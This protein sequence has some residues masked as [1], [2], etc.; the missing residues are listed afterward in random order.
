MFEKKAE[1]Y[2][3]AVS[4][5][6]TCQPAWHLRK[7]KLRTASYPFDWIGTP[8]DS[9]CTLLAT[10]F[11]DFF[12]RPY[13]HIRGDNEIGKLD[14]VNTKY[15][16]LFAHDFTAAN[17]FDEEYPVLKDKFERRIERFCDVLKSGERVLLI[18]IRIDREDARKITDTLNRKFPNLRYTL[19]A[20]DSTEEIREDWHIPNVVNRY[21]DVAPDHMAVDPGHDKPWKKA[22]KSFQYN[23][24][25]KECRADFF[26]SSLNFQD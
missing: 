6:G 17:R 21:V 15:K 2:R 18:R 22:L 23:I 19:F 20:V 12:H 14:V 26:K 11:Q 7:N 1:P 5:G 25:R 24:D 9:L 10:D 3:Y 4:L 16:I 13:L 8:T